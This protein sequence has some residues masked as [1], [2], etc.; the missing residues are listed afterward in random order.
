ME[1]WYDT[2]YYLRLIR[3]FS[4][5]QIDEQVTQFMRECPNSHLDAM[6]ANMDELTKWDET[7]I[8]SEEFS[9][10]ID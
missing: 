10:D 9:T 4:E 8:I 6:I 3:F 5:E 1:W 7:I 2:G